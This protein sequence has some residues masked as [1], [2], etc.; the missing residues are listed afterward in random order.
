[1]KTRFI[2]GCLIT[3][4]FL[5]GPGCKKYLDKELQGV[6]SNTTFYQT[7]QQALQAVNAAYQPLAFTSATSNALWVFGDVASDDAEKGG[8]VGDET[9]IG[10]IDQFNITPINGNLGNE[11][12]TLYEG[13]TRCNMVLAK[14]PAISMDTALKLQILGEA[15]FLRSWYYF[16]LVNIFGDVPVVLT[17]L[18]ADQL[19]IEQ[20][21]AK[22]IFESVIEPDLR[23]ASVQLPSSYTTDVG[24]ATSGAAMA[25]L[26]KAYLFQNKWDSAMASAGSVINSAQYSLMPVYSQNFSG[27]YKNNSESV[28]EVQMLNGQ[29]PQAGNALNQWFAPAVYGGY[30]FDAPTQGFVD[31]FEKTPAGVVDP[32]L[33]YTVGRDSMAWFNGLIFSSTW[34]PTGYLTRKHQQPLSEAPIIG[35]GGCDYVAIRYADVL[36]WYAESLN[37][38]GSSAAALVPLNQVR[39]RAR[40]SYLYDTTLTAPMDTAGNRQVPPNLLPDL[41]DVDQNVIR[42][43]IQ[44]ERRVELGFEFHR[45]FDIIRWGA[46][47]AAQAMS[48]SPN[49]N[50]NTNKHFPIPQSERDTDKA[51]H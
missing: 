23:I 26:A 43:A 50:Y 33:D 16:T 2:P 21:P 15:R 1:M 48:G 7:Q 8:N 42:A 18:N 37:E 14:V 13:I 11:W 38:L 45:Y 22:T 20:S 19:Q 27:H 6:Y 25:L 36:L 30:Y 46:A 32:R 49:F 39:K 51:L 5:A 10:L 35:D 44:H 47:Y 28:F 24:R 31:E 34:S 12:G 40:E 29:T 17:P 4:F 9:D 3:V 41:T